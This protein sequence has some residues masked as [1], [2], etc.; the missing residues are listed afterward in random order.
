MEEYKE[1]SMLA[2]EFEANVE[3]GMIKIPRKFTQLENK[4]MKVL[5]FETGAPNKPLPESFFEPIVI[6]SYNLIAARDEIY[7]IG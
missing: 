6:P 2:V 1:H 7:E 5:L 4:H 3:G